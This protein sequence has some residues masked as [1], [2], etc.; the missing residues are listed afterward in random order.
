MAA[1]VEAPCQRM[2]IPTVRVLI[3]YIT[4]GLLTDDR[5]GYDIRW[6]PVGVDEIGDGDHIPDLF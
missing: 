4:R 3:A 1:L 5:A 2:L 6:N